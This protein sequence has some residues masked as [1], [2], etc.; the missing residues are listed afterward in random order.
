[1]NAAKQIIREDLCRVLVLGAVDVGKSTFC[2]ELLCA[3]NHAGRMIR[4]VDSDV[5]QKLIGPPAC[6]TLGQA[7]S[8]AE[9]SLLGLVFVGTTSPVR[10]W[11]QLISGT[12]HMVERAGDAVVVINTGGLLSGPGR[13]LKLE[14]VSALKPDLV[15]GIGQDPELNAVLNEA[16]DLRIMKLPSSPLARRKTEGERRAARRE[17]F[18]AY[19][20]PAIEVAIAMR[21][22]EM[23]GAPTPHAYPPI[24]LLV[25]LAAASGRDLGLGVVVSVDTDTA[26]II[27]LTPVD[28]AKVALLR[29]GSITL[30]STLSDRVAVA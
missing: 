21:D 26:T 5:G 8:D 14:K 29:W 10:A 25:G 7:T 17:A 15:I 12:A 30:D 9:L 28:P 6:V 2:R 20:A 27:C 16:S 13:R 18:R 3:A 1:L 11:R 19:F 23:I 22:L 4:L 24:R